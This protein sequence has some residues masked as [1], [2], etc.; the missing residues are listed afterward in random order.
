MLSRFDA[1]T[2][3]LLSALTTTLYVRPSLENFVTFREA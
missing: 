2:K 1:S 3:Y